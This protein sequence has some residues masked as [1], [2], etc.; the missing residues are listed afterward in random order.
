M[1][2]CILTRADSDEYYNYDLATIKSS[3]CFWTAF[4]VVMRVRNS[5]CWVIEPL[6]RAE[7]DAREAE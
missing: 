2:P 7:L 1:K 5:I 4:G 3:R 6:A